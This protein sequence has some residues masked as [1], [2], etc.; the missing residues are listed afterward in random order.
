MSHR[1]SKLPLI[2][3]LAATTFAPLASAQDAVT[4]DQVVATVNGTDITLGHMVV[5]RAGLPPQYAQVPAET[6]F[7]GILDQLV[8]KT[9]LSQ[10]LEGGP[11]KQV[12]LTIENETR[13]IIASQV[14]NSVMGGAVTEEA[15]QAAYEEQYATAEPAT[16]YH[17][18]HIL[19]E[20]EDE[21]KDLISKLDDG[22]E[23]AA[24]AQEFSTGP[25]GAGGGDLGW[26]GAGVMV[27]PFFDAVTGLE[28]GQVSPPVQT[29]FGWHVILLKETRS[30]DRPAL[31]DVQAEIEGVLKNSA[32]EAYVEKLEASS[33][34]DRPDL[35]ALDPEILNDTSL[36][37]N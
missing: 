27:A 30:K 25:S 36:L 21:A 2:A 26:F 15:V 3:F 10:S 8:Q 16:E 20:T 17:A 7:N 1:L 29:D 19:V 18:A 33:E 5:L 24:L 4:S 32:L 22:A 11:S 9:L 6:L 31:V 12:A 14:I 28:P 37:E 13:A 34:V 23:F 35:S